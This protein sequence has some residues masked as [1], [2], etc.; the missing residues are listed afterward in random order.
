MKKITLILGVLGFY[1]ASAQDNDFLN[2]QKRLKENYI[3][4]QITPP[5][6]F[7]HNVSNLPQAR[8]SQVLPNGNKVY[9]LP[10]DNMP[11][12][13][14]DMSQFNMVNAAKTPGNS[15][16]NLL[17]QETMPNAVT[18]YPIIPSKITNQKH[19]PSR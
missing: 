9:S 13:V 12:V 18:P 7:R 4:K 2:L 15:N 19:N 16:S 14:P 8:L 3:R 10:Q 1:T 11:D 6:V 17:S 5:P